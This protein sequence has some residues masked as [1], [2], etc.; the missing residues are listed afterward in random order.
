[1]R[2]FGRTKHD[3]LGKIIRRRGVKDAGII[4][5]ALLSTCIAQTGCGAL[6]AHAALGG[7]ITEAA[8]AQTD[9][10]KDLFVLADD[11]RKL[12][13]AMLARFDVHDACAKGR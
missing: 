7:R 1:M 13:A 8:T 10:D 11:L 5:D 6:I 3:A 2:P 12:A 4:K 9:A